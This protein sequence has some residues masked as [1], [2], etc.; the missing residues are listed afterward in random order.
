MAG[1]GVVERLSSSHLHRL[2]LGHHLALEVPR[3]DHTESREKGD[4]G[5]DP[6]RL[7]V[8]P[9]VR[10][11]VRLA[12]VPQT[13]R[14]D[15]GAA[16]HVSARDRVREGHQLDLVGEHGNEVGHLRAPGHRVEAI[17]DRVLHEGV[18][19][20]DEVGRQ[21]GA[22]RDQPHAGRVQLRR[23]LVPSEDPQAEEGRLE[24]ERQ[25]RLDSQRCTEDVADEAR[26]VAPVHPELELLDDSRDKAK[27]EVD[28]EQLAE[29]LGQTQHLG[30]AV[31]KPCG[32]EAGDDDRQANRDRDEE[33][34]VDGRDGELP[35][36][37]VHGVHEA[38]SVHWLQRS[39]QILRICARPHDLFQ[40]ARP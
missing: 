6:S 10:S 2:H 25:Q 29:E 21:Q 40:I 5:A 4:P 36:R 17:A 33:E 13:H 28:R 8:H 27:G 35:S 14:H 32:L 34:V 19:S 7:S 26:V 24:E 16:D 22:D 20:Q 3:D 18:G 11:D 15:E 1:L 37:D 23:E 12:Q 9:G 39:P 30:V 31:A 38:P